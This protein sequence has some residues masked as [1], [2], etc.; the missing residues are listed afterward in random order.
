MLAMIVDVVATI[1]SPSVVIFQFLF[2]ANSRETTI[3]TNSQEAAIITMRHEVQM[4]TPRVTVFL[5]RQ[6]FWKLVLHF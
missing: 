4:S 3:I 5:L 2:N 6:S 1:S